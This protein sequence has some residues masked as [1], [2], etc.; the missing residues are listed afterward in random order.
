MPTLIVGNGDAAA[1]AIA[2]VDA[3]HAAVPGRSLVLSGR[4]AAD[5][6]FVIPPDLSAFAEVRRPGSACAC[7]LGE[8]VFRVALV[9]WLREVRPSSLLIELLPGWHLESFAST[10]GGHA[11]VDLVRV[12]RVLD[13]DRESFARSPAG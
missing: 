5:P 6:S 7:C 1:R 2:L 11:F 3:V 10:L 9:R 13:L 8:V 12:D 4:F